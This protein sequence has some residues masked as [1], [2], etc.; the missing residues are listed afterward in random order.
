MK[1]FNLLIATSIACLA[2]SACGAKEAIESIRP[3]SGKNGYR[4]ITTPDLSSAN[5]SNVKLKINGKTY[6]SGEKIDIATLHQNTVYNQSYE[7]TADKMENGRKVNFKEEGTARI[8]KNKYSV[9]L[10]AHVEK[11][12]QNNIRNVDKSK[13][14]A[15]QG[16]ATELAKLPTQGNFLYEGQAFTGKN[17]TGRLIYNVNFDRREGSGT[18]LNLGKY[19]KISLGTGSIKEF[20]PNGTF[21]GKV[22]IEGRASYGKSS[23]SY[24]LGFFGPKA[25]EIAGQAGLKI[26]GKDVNI[27]FGGRKQPGSK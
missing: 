18:I 10:A 14:L 4:V 24:K 7:M 22:G 23:G 17:D 12:I 8:Y 20:K 11:E 21:G 19:D 2:L 25:E 3:P 6:Q 1:T 5:T 27:G 26:E 13:V 16:E 15:V 9:V